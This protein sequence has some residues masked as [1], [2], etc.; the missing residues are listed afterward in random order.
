MQ[1][2]VVVV[3]GIIWIETANPIFHVMH[4]LQGEVGMEAFVMMQWLIS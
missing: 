2:G 1:Q 4:K 3:T